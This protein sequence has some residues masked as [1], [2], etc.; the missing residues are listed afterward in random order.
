MRQAFKAARAP[1]ERPAPEDRWQHRAAKFERLSRESAEREGLPRILAEQIRETDV[2]VDIGA[3]T[4]RHALLFAHR[5]RK[6]FAVEPSASMRARLAR[7][8]E[9]EGIENVE[10]VDATWPDAAGLEGDVLFS[11]HVL[12]GID[13]AA[14]FLATMSAASRRLCA[15]NLGLRAPGA[16]LD[17]LWTHIHGARVPPRP[18]ALE[19]LTVLHQLGAQA[20]LAVVVGSERSFEFT[21][22]DDDVIELCHR[23][24]LEPSAAGLSRVRAG[25]AALAPAD[26][27][28]MHVLG[29]TG[30]NALLW[31]AARS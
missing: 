13:D 26:E 18:A 28:G 12:Y 5:C 15:L 23:L 2:V 30:P 11:S 25:L 7:R 20:S 4:G 6:V 16:A 19:A 1:F 29:V 27:R 3:G 31:W 10:I 22:A 8:L 24:D 14:T 17:P 21:S 9:E